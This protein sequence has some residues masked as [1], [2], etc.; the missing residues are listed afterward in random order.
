MTSKSEIGQ[1]RYRVWVLSTGE[2]RIDPVLVEFASPTK[3]WVCY[4]SNPWQKKNK[5]NEFDRVS[6]LSKYTEN[7]ERLYSVVEDAIAYAQT[8]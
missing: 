6:G 5:H 3:V 8:L 7:K 1:T 4:A 2:V